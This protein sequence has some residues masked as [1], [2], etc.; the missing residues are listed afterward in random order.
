MLVVEFQSDSIFTCHTKLR[1]TKTPPTTIHFGNLQLILFLLQ[2]MRV[3][4]S[5]FRGTLYTF[6]IV[7]RRGICCKKNI[8]SS[9]ELA[10]IAPTTLLT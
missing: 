6:F 9:T 3:D 4:S 1:V 10:Y 5:L 8:D 7:T 2:V